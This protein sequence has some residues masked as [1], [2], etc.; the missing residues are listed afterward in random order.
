MFVQDHFFS[1]LVCV[2]LIFVIATVMLLSDTGT[3]GRIYQG[4]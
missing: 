4:F 1:S 3:S 2:V